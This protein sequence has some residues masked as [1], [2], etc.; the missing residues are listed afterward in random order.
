MA[1]LYFEDGSKTSDWQQIQH[2]LEDL[3]I[4]LYKWQVSSTV[5]DLTDKQSLT[6]TEKETVLRGLDHYFHQL[7][8]SDGYQTRDLIVLHNDIPNLDVL[9][10][11]FERAHTH[12][13]DEVRYI[14]DGE[15]VFGFT[16]PDK[17]QVEL[18]VEAEEYINVPKDTEH[19]FYLTNTK[20]IKAIR[21]FTTMDGW[22]PVYTGTKVK[23]EKKL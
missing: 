15:G 3:G 5:K 16:K 21:Y 11:K 14:I 23:M 10:N 17:S 20:R 19:W 4:S 1:T 22:S 8:Q 6:D 9:L 18:K 2:A 12:D 13:D 7:Q